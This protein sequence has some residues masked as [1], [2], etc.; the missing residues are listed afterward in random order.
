MRRAKYWSQDTSPI[1]SSSLAGLEAW[2]KGWAGAFCA[3]NGDP[4]PYHDAKMHTAAGVFVWDAE[5][6]LTAGL[7]DPPNLNKQAVL[8]N[9]TAIE[10]ISQQHCSTK[11]S[12]QKQQMAPSPTA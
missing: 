9:Y 4:T 8:A 11:A 6:C 1:D 10:E 3:L 5:Y 7:I 2:T 12:L